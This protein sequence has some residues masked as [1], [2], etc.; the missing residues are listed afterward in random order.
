MWTIE[1]LIGSRLSNEPASA[2]ESISGPMMSD[3]SGKGMDYG[4]Q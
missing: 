3:Q 1:V 4:S 2:I